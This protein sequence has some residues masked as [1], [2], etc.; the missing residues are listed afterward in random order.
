MPRSPFRN[1][2]RRVPREPT[3]EHNARL[4][5]DIG[6]KLSV[7]GMEMRREVLSNVHANVDAVKVRDCRQTSSLPVSREIL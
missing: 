2:T 6:F 7:H 3:F 4:N 5:G 1:E